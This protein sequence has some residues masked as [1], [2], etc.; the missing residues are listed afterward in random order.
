MTIKI[1]IREAVDSDS[2]GIEQTLQQAFNDHPHSSNNEH[3]IVSAL[4]QQQQLSLMLV[5]V[6][7]AS[8][9]A[10]LVGC[11]AFSPVTIM[12]DSHGVAEEMPHARWCA[13]GPVAV[14][15]D[16][17]REGIGSKLIQMGLYQMKQRAFDGCVL[18]GEPAFYR[19]FGFLQHSGLV[20]PGLPAEYFHS[21]LWRGEQ[22]Q[23]T[24]KYAA[25]FSEVT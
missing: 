7:T 6:D 14:R 4:R 12:L 3:K 20:F 10:P 2:P 1:K 18:V 25:A 22:P 17:Q 8:D 13:L 24:V 21:L 15:P 9:A 11:V 16:Q 23:G 5:A 19:R